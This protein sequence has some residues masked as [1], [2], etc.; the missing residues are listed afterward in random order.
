M[1]ILLVSPYFPPQNAVASLRMHGF[2]RA[3][4]DAGDQVTVLTTVKRDDQCGLEL[5]CDGITIAEID[6]RVPEIFEWLR[7]WYKRAHSTGAATTAT[8]SGLSWLSP[9]KERTGIF[10]SV[11]MPDLTDWWIKPAVQ[12]ARSQPAGWDVVM[13]SSGPYTAHLAALAIK[14]AGCA[15]RWAADFRDLWTQN[16]LHTGLFPLTLREKFL[17]RQ[18][19]R[20]AD[21]ISAATDGLAEKLQR[22]SGRAVDVIYNGFDERQAPSNT[23]QVRGEGD[24]TVRLV[25]TGTWYSRGQDPA[26]LLSALAS[27]RN[28]GRDGSAH[29][30][31]V[32]AGNA[33][34]QWLRTAERFGVSDMIEHHGMIS[35]TE[36]LGLQ[37]QADALILLDWNDSSQGVLTAKVFEYLHASAPILI[38]GGAAGSPMARLVERAGRGSGLRTFDQIATALCELR[39]HR[40]SLKANPD[41][42][43]INSL[44]RQRQSMRLLHRMRQLTPVTP[45]PE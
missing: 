17:E 3:W 40:A 37:C 39:D 28:S 7:A 14:R 41:C 24:G 33:R 11:R 10:C 45:V 1:R 23:S 18:C 31:L 19:L 4:T 15:K 21:L 26:P 29:L 5:A 8:P 38:I 2:A 25:Y 30:S 27:T 12:W 20:E 22:M 6:Y 9:I 13:S 16:H 35:R 36:A 44:S 42:E 34:D 43:F 32:V